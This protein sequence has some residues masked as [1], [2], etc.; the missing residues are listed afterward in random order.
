MNRGLVFNFGSFFAS[1]ES[2]SG[3]AASSSL[4]VW[5][6]FW[7]GGLGHRWNVRVPGFARFGGVVSL[8]Q[9]RGRGWDYDE[10]LARRTLDLLPTQA[11]VALQV[12]FAVRAG[13]LEIAHGPECSRRNQIDNAAFFT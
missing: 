3:P 9:L 4:W 12:L 5:W 10:V 2:E 7:S 8:G 6:G 11:V 13:E 1:N